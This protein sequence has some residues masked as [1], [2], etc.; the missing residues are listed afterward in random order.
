MNHSVVVGVIALA[1]LGCLW[2]W[3]NGVR[4][5]KKAEKA[6]KQAGRT[7]SVLGWGLM[8]AGVIVGIQWLV[9]VF[10]HDTAT[11]LLVLGIPGFFAGM[12]LSRFCAVTLGSTGVESRYLRGGGPR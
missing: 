5:G 6:L 2:L 9:V 1:A 7:G 8:C 10:S 11:V 12:S 3:G 4:A